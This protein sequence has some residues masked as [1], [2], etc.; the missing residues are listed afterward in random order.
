MTKPAPAQIPIRSADD[1]TARWATV[2][3]PPV[4]GHRSLWLLWLDDNGLMLPVVV[5]IDDVPAVPD[6]QLIDSL[7]LMSDT[8]LQ[9]HLPDDDGHIGFA[10]CR[11]G[12]PEVT[13]DDDA[14]AEALQLEFDDASD[15]TWSLHL[16]AA[17]R[18][19]PLIGPPPFLWRHRR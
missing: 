4:F 10:L 1:L 15:G 2:L 14:W 3:D 16:A 19:T 6:R 12:P 17:G 7:L 9:E 18:V 11:P 8:V 13:A 5:P